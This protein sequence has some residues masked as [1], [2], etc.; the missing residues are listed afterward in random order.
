V[1]YK[2][3]S[4][5]CPSA[6]LGGWRNIEATYKS[7]ETKERSE[8]SNVIAEAIR[9]ATASSFSASGGVS[10]AYKAV[11]GSASAS[12]GRSSDSS[13]DSS[14]TNGAS[15]DTAQASKT[16][17]I[18]VQQAWK[19]GSSGTDPEAW[20]RSLDY[21]L[22]SNWKVIDHELPKCIGIWQFVGDTFTRDGLCNAWLEI[23]L[24][25]GPFDKVSQFIEDETR[26]K[27]C[28]ST[29]NMAEL[30]TAVQELLRLQTAG[31][32]R[33]AKERCDNSK[34]FQQFRLVPTTLRDANQARA[35]LRGVRLF[36]N[37][38][39][40]ANLIITSSLGKEDGDYLFNG[41][42]PLILN[43]PARVS[44]TEF[45]FLL[46]PNIANK[47]QDP[48]AFELYG[49]DDPLGASNLLL[50]FKMDDVTKKITSEPTPVRQ[51]WSPSLG[52]IGGAAGY[53]WNDQQG[54]CQKRV[55]SATCGSVDCKI[56]G[57]F[58]VLNYAEATSFCSGETCTASD[59]NKCCSDGRYAQTFVI[60][61][62]QSLTGHEQTSSAIAVKLKGL[63]I[64]GIPY[65][66]KNNPSADAG[67]LDG[68]SGYFYLTGAS[69]FW[70]TTRRVKMGV[71][72]PGN[73]KIRI[74]EICIWLT[75]V[76]TFS[77]PNN[78]NSLI[79]NQRNT[80]LGLTSLKILNDEGPNTLVIADLAGWRRQ[81]EPLKNARVTLEQCQ[82]VTA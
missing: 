7:Q 6:I 16:T 42:A 58:G 21:S 73:P 4:H 1:I 33:L 69:D 80:V 63:T 59:A 25:G 19:G 47:G 5:I 81:A 28:K 66:S 54:L 8:V 46:S 56:L 52:L 30:R 70:S 44:V 32:A 43:L 22:N 77:D 35:R 71:P 49:F 57:T 64:E 15:T 13:S 37:G 79:E 40:A 3:G 68:N 50:K 67:N 20:R 36:S 24:G 78:G 2:F 55:A 23:Y 27:V 38:V 41:F 72:G 53:A 45:A 26:D 82:S 61:M 39:I 65:D 29:R 60:E 74:T 17:N 76:S 31:E 12:G 48:V 34:D 62:T 9:E 14:S 75:G 10:G 18:Q 51:A 11:S